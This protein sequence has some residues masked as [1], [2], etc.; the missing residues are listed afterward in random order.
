MLRYRFSTPAQRVIAL[1]LSGTGR[2]QLTDNGVSRDVSPSRGAEVAFEIAVTPGDSGT[3]EIRRAG[4]ARYPLALV[5]L[6]ADRPFL[7]SELPPSPGAH[8]A[9][10][11]STKLHCCFS[12][13]TLR[14]RSVNL[15]GEATLAVP[16]DQ[17]TVSLLLPAENSGYLRLFPLCD[18]STFRDQFS[19]DDRP[20]T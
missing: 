11:Q 14:W 10:S 18:C 2:V 8:G 1:T 17:L 16:E 3:V 12:G 19:F 13:L 15:R 9:F 5:P 20:T 4:L 7:E 6:G